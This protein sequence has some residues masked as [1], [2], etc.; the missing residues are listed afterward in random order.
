M[1]YMSRLV[2]LRSAGTITK[3]PPTPNKPVS[4]PAITPSH[5]S[6]EAVLTFQIKRPVD[7][8]TLQG[9]FSNSLTLLKK[10]R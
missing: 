1:L 8:L 4:K 6:I 9:G 5:P 10:I 2:I 3:P 7:G